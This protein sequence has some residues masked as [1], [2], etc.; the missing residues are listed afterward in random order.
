MH[1]NLFLNRL[2]IRTNEG[3]TA[4]DENFHRGVNIIRGDNSS[5]KSTISHFIFYVLG[6]AFS[7]WV[8][9]AKKCSE[10]LAEVEMNKSVFTIKREVSEHTKSPIFIHWGTMDDL[11]NNP[12]KYTWNKFGYDTTT[13]KKSFSNVFFENLGLPIVYGDNNITM[14]QILRLLYVDQDSPTNSLFLYEQFDSQLNR[15]TISDLLLG[16]Y[17]EKL[18]NNKIDLREKESEFDKIKGEITGVKKFIGNAFNLTPELINTQIDNT[19]KS[20][21]EIENQIVSL[22]EGEKRVNYS[23]KSK[24]EF[25]KLNIDVIK[26]RTKVKT[27]EDQLSL[28]KYEIDDTDF[29]ID[30]LEA[31]LKAIRNSIITRDFLGEFQLD[32]CPECL[33]R[34]E[35][36]Q[37]ENHCKLCKE[38][39]D[40]SYGVT[41]ARKIE[42]EL[43]FQIKESRK[44]LVTK[45]VSKDELEIRLHSE[46][47]ENN[48]IQISVNN[49]LKDVKSFRNEKIDQLYISKGF[50][51]G[52]IL[53]QR[54]LLE[55][56]EAYANLNERK[57]NLENRIAVL[58]GAIKSGLAEQEKL[59][60]NINK[61]VKDCGLDLLRNDL[62]RQREFREAKEF[63]IDYRNNLA[64]LDDKELRFSASSDFY[65]KTTARYSLFFAALEVESMRYPRF[66]LCDNMED[67]G[68]EAIRAKN[69]QKLIV[70]KANS[71]NKDDFQL[72]YTTSFIPEELNV[73]QYTVGKFYTEATPSLSVG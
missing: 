52:E 68:I 57:I 2:V 8:K 19:Q 61:K 33:K 9:E 1:N 23:V 26:Q 21:I 15:E 20:I 65:L 69:F 35:D 55:N 38:P 6:G 66:I 58:K 56:A 63:N 46:R 18:Y 53:Q 40:N 71:Y 13:E 32:H 16:V 59:K 12:E 70:E 51:E 27:T 45:L 64:F 31:K 14:H 41:Q 24:L 48:Q 42:Q 73:E 29:F 11:F 39:A 49:A 34:I 10:V 43:D 7:K 36:K 37:I 60:T 50:Q 67:K 72:I 3:G 17:E 25:E 30:S 47:I 54:T 5:G 22:K 4:Y 44:N 28:V 62:Y